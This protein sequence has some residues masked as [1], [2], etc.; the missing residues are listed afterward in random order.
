MPD[1][2]YHQELYPLNKPLVMSET[3]M[4]GSVEAYLATTFFPRRGLAAI[5]CSACFAPSEAGYR[6][7]RR[8][9]E[10]Q[11]ASSSKELGRGLRYGYGN[12]WTE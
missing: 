3:V 9:A 4:N 6:W 7:A 11:M 8:K 10:L 12:V 5:S 2:L 1:T